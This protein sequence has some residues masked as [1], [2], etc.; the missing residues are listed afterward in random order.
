[1]RASVCPF[2]AQKGRLAGR[3]SSSSGHSTAFKQFALPFS[4]M[5]RGKQSGAI[6]AER[7]VS[8]S[9]HRSQL[10]HD[11][12]LHSIDFLPRAPFPVFVG[13]KTESRLTTICCV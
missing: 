11:D 8:S 3:L 9:I 1:M 6:K 7:R 10:G 13:K 5:R 4:S 12:V 2:M